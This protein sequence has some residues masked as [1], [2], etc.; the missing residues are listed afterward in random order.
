MEKGNFKDE[1]MKALGGNINE[2]SHIKEIIEK[3]VGGDNEGILK[4]ILMA[5][6]ELNLSK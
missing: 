4:D 2:K 5:I 3:H 6:K 1:F